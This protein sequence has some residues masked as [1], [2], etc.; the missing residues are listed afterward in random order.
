MKNLLT[1]IM[2]FLLIPMTS[3]AGEYSC[4]AASSSGSLRFDGPVLFRVKGNQVVLSAK[5]ISNF[6]NQTSGD[7]YL[8][9]WAT[10]SPYSGGEMKGFVMGAGKVGKI[11]AGGYIQ[12]Y[13]V[14]SPHSKPSSGT[15]YFTM[16]LTEQKKGSEAIIDYMPFPKAKTIGR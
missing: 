6:Q 3:A 8:K 13:E 1:G 7:L 12:D 5:K 11:N 16:T 15:Y 2:L 14:T 10:P 4:P 9:L